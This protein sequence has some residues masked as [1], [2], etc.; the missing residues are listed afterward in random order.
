MARPPWIPDPLDRPGSPS[1]AA[2]CS[3]PAADPACTAVPRTPAHPGS[4][5]PGRPAQ[6]TMAACPQL[7]E[8]AGCES[9]AQVKPPYSYASLICM[10]MEASGEPQIPLSAIYRWITDNFC[11]FRHA[12]P[13]W[14]NSIRH[15]LSSNKCFIR[16]PREKDE[17]GKGGFW[18]M[19][20]LR[21][22]RLQKGAC[23]KRRRSPAQTHPAFTEAAQQE[24]GCDASPA[25]PV[26]T[27]TN[28]LRVSRESQQLLQE[29]E[30]VMGSQTCDPAGGQAGQKHQQ[31]SPTRPAKVAR[32]SSSDLLSQEEQEELG[33]L[34]GDWDWEAI[35]NTSLN[36]DLSTF[37]DLDLLPPTGPIMQDLDLM[38]CGQHTEGPQGQEQVLTESQQNSP[39][40][41]E[42]FMAAALLQSPWDEGTSDCLTNTVSMEEV[43]ECDDAPLPEE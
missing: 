25:T 16:V 38:V 6:R 12:N 18:K 14:Q 33:S 27:P 5:S 17:P 20:P 11:Y 39:G 22:E 23:R 31:P 19:D 7:P 40:W 29:F 24:P 15:N 43:F 42:T 26:C 4:S 30:E 37:G 28:V 13:T 3:P 36:A 8:D 41:D 1:F 10:A 2:P 21:A 35:F 32:L 34:K 9:D